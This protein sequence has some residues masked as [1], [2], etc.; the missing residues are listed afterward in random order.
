MPIIDTIPAERLALLDTALLYNGPHGGS[1]GPGCQHC[2]RELL[3][4][5]VTGEHKDATPP[6][7]TEWAGILPGINDGPWRDDAHRTE[8]MRPYLRKFL[9]PAFGGLDPARDEARV[10][11]V[12]DWC[13]RDALPAIVVRDT[14]KGARAIDLARAL[15]LAL[16]QLARQSPESWEKAV[17][18]LLDRICAIP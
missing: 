14:A 13:Y 15:D 1:G 5:V 2:A 8:V 17:R 9:P 12:L 6:G 11:A 10:Y 3:Y 16:A 7:C 18:A 4:E